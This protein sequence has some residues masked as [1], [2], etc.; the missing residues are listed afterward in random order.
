MRRSAGEGSIYKRKDGSWVDQYEVAGKR[1]YLYGKTRK[2]VDDRLKAKTKGGGLDLDAGA[3]R[4]RVEAFLDRWLPAVKGTVR[5][6]TFKRH[7]EAVRLHIKPSLGGLNLSK[8]NVLDVQEMYLSKLDEG[9]SPRTVQIVHSTLHKALK[10]AVA[11]SLVSKNVTEAVKPPQAQMK[12]MRTLS[13]VEVKR[14]LLAARGERFEVLYILAVTTGMRQGELLGLKHEDV[15]LEDEILRVRRTV[16][17]GVAGPPKS[18][19]ST[20]SICLTRLAVEALREHKE[21]HKGAE[22]VFSTRNGTP[23]N[24]HNLVNRSWRP[25]LDRAGLP[26]IPFH[27]LRHSCAT[28]LLSRNVNPKIVQEMLG[29]ATISITLD[30]YSHVLPN[31]QAGAVEAMEDVL[32]I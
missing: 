13:P 26:R 14:L 25:L 19:T 23:V 16:R 12:E 18:A 27:N 2:A 22:W 15:D 29:H 3:E 9:L 31:M 7:E 32:K 17:Q 4:M 11:W 1:R 5:L 28:L 24:G 30:T 20:R 21:E 6:S 10:Q 8:L